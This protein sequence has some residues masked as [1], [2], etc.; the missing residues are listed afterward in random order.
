MAI[1]EKHIMFLGGSGFLGR[2]ILKE[3]ELAGARITAIQNNRAIESRHAKITSSSLT[4]MDWRILDELDVDY[5]IHAA[6]ISGNNKKERIHF[7]QQAS[8]A[9]E[10]LLTQVASMSKKPIIIYVSG[11]L[12]YGSRK[13]AITELSPLQP[14]GFQKEYVI[15]EHPFLTALTDKNT[16]LNIVRPGWILG[17]GSWLHHFYFKP[18]FYK[19]YIPVYGNGQNM[20]SIIQVNDCARM[21]IYLMESA[22]HG[23]IYNLIGN[24]CLQQNEFVKILRQI[25]NLKIKHIPKFWLHLRYGQAVMESL[26]FN[27]KLSTAYPEVFK[28]FNYHCQ[29]LKSYL[30]QLWQNYKS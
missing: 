11:S 28:S 26:T 23:R 21:I 24:H 4:Q 16:P 14:T 27:L 13:T 9:H 18:M 29:D 19:K 15:A 2:E 12:V 10:R 1:K 30:N 17:P 25:S 3:L 20:M 6:R 5:I 7:S 8:I 22:T